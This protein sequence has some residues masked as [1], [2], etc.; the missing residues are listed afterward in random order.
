MIRQTLVFLSV[1]MLLSM[2]TGCSTCEPVAPLFVQGSVRAQIDQQGVL[3]KSTVRE[4][5]MTIEL[6]KPGDSRCVPADEPFNL[7]IPDAID[8]AR[9]ALQISECES[10]TVTAGGQSFQITLVESC[11]P[12]LVLKKECK[13]LNWYNPYRIPEIRVSN[14]SL[15]Q[16]VLT[17]LLSDDNE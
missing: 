8:M 9:Y 11:M 7:D 16:L 17:P 5:S 13:I 1:V 15:S 12:V 2:L 4:P 10:P 6:R 14:D 3:V